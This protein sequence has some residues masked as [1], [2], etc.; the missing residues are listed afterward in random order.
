[1]AIDVKKLKEVLLFEFNHTDRKGIYGYTQRALAYNSNKIEGSTLTIEQTAS[2]FETGELASDGITVYR[3]KDIE[4]MQGH[5]MMF[6]HM[7]KTLQESLSEQLIKA[8]HKQLKQGVFEDRANGYAIGDYKTR[9]NIVNDINTV[10]P[11]EVE[12]HMQKLLLDYHARAEKTLK[13]IAAFHYEFE[14]IHPF[15]DGNGRVGRM[16]MFR[17]CIYHGIAPFI[18][19]DRCRHQ[20]INALHYAQETGD[21]NRLADYFT[22]EQSEYEKQIE[23]FLDYEIP[24]FHTRVKNILTDCYFITDDKTQEFIIEML[25]KAA[26]DDNQLLRLSIMNAMQYLNLH[27]EEQ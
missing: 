4:E 7:L 9:R 12:A 8:F 23:H 13:D 15:Q 1:M 21:V 27:K 24:E 10:L 22:E 16:I 14:K 2:L 17:E 11:E 26:A 6:N 18:V 25:P 3:A 19:N 20:Y 5:F